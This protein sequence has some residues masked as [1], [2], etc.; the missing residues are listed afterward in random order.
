VQKSDQKVTFQGDI[1]IMVEADNQQIGQVMT[2]FMTNAIKYAP[3]SKIIV[4]AELLNKG[5]V[6][7]NV[8]DNGT[9]G[10]ADPS[11]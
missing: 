8:K 11:I 4:R 3:D 7:I 5:E 6:K 10:K 1:S 2:N 9:K